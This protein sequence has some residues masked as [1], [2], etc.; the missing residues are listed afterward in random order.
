SP[1]HLKFRSSLF[2]GLRFPKAEPLVGFKGEAL[3][4][5]CLLSGGFYPPLFLLLATLVKKG[6]G[7]C[8]PPLGSKRC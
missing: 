6:G 4:I 1:R 5:L 8:P 3:N 7:H 2:K